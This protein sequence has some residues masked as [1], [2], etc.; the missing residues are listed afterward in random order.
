MSDL[1]FTS[2]WDFGDGNTTTAQH[3]SHRYTDTGYYTVKLVVRDII[4]CEDSLIKANAVRV[5]LPVASFTANNFDTYCLP[6]QAKFTNSSSYTKGYNWNLSIAT[7]TQENPAIY[8]TDPGVYHITLEVTSPG[9]CTDTAIDTLIVHDASSAQIN[10]EPLIGC[11][12][13]PVNFEA[14]TEMNARFIWDFGDGNVIDTN[15]NKFTHLYDNFGGFIPKIIL[16]EPEGCLIT[17][18]GNETIQI[19]GAKAKFDVTTLLFCDNGYV[20]ILDSTTSRDRIIRYTWDFGDGTVSNNPVPVHNYTSPGNYPVSLLVETETG[21]RDSLTYKTPVKVVNSPLIAITGDSVI[22]VNERLNVNGIFLRQD[23]SAVSWLWQFG[24]GNNSGSQNPD[25]QQYTPG[26]YTIN[27]VAT[28]SS[29]CKDTV[30]W[31]ARIN[32][33]PVIN[34]TSPITKIV[35][36][37]IQLSVTYSNNIQSYTWLPVN[38]LSCT[39]CPEPTTDIKFSTDYVVSVVDSNNCLNAE[40]VRVIVLCKG[41]EIFIPNTFSPNGD[42][43]N[44]FF[45]PRGRGIERIRTLRIFNRWGEVVFE[46]REFPINDP[47]AG[48]DGKFKNGAPQAGVYVYQAELIC[49]NGEILTYKGNIALIL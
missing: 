20:N 31:D 18:T 48:W 38:G 3:T 8:Y 6:F 39:D 21:C 14:F 44:D 13:F 16:Q 41:A 37:P 19:N 30:Q 7:S 36:I 32:P 2:L 15:V 25:P 23:T 35:G 42:G 4:G 26:D 40:Q 33:L 9:G 1:P 49:E 5:S 10:Y 29:G 45:Y 22:C 24:N 17:L 43:R 34:A 47:L 11:R 46:N 28:N 27:T 12:P